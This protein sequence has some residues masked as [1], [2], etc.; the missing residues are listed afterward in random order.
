MYRDLTVAV[1]V[2]AYNEVRLIG[3]T[4][5]T[6]PG[7]VDHIVVIDDC[8][9]D[10]TSDEALS[11]GDP[12]VQ[13][14]RHLRNTGVGGAILD[15][16]RL[17]LDL[18]ADVSVVMAGD[19]QMDPAYLP[20][21][22]DPIADGE[23]EFTK[24]NRFFS[25][26]SFTGMPKHRV[27][28]S[29]IL[30]FM[31]KASSGYWHLFDPQNG[32]TA[33]S[34][35]ALRAIALDRVATGYEFEND[36]LIRLSIANVRARDVPVPAVY[37]AEVSGMRLHKVIPAVSW[38][39]FRGFWKRI[40]VKY[41]L[42]SF[43][44]VAL[45]L[46]AGMALF[47]FGTAFGLGMTLYRIFG[48]SAPSAGTVLLAVT[49]LLAGLHLIISAWTLD[50]QQAPDRPVWDAGSGAAPARQRTLT[51]SATAT[52]ADLTSAAATAGTASAA[53]LAE[54]V[55]AALVPGQS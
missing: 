37:G 33:T 26:T 47:G 29:V 52:T 16:H 21:L 55:S 30:S 28:G 2:P 18:E 15:G 4:I 48:G 38:L 8:S 49:P 32:Y 12:R 22:L 34:A 46:F 11:V 14:I 13:L 39:L 24:A 9:T 53:S 23:A 20:A 40:L 27:F 54:P 6:M 35:R 31:T 7:F 43:S 45:L 42:Q 1:V 19:A 17:A 44:P 10:N 51:P 25:R 5:R 3:K 41:V 36:L 50:I